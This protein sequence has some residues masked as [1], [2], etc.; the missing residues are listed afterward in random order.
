[1]NNELEIKQELNGE[2]TIDSREVAEMVEKPHD[3]LM[4][5][6]RGYI[7]VLDDSAKLQTPNFF[8]ES[9]YINSQ[10]K[11]QPCYLLTKKGCDMVANKMTGEKGILFTAEYVTKFDE[12]EKQ[13]KSNTPQISREQQLVLSIYNGGIEAVEATKELTQLKVAEAVAPLKL[14]IENDKPLVEFSNQISKSV[15]SIDIGQFSK[16][17]KDE[18]IDIGRN[19]LF[20]WLR[21][22][23]YLMKDNVPY[24]SKIE[25]GLFE[26]KEYTYKTPYGVKN[27]VKC[28]VTGK[29]QIFLVEKLRKE[30]CYEQLNASK[31]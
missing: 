8:I 12:M 2:L 6:I 10:N 9:T 19:R 11:Q 23:K 1:M 24:Q 13:I 26:V 30:F 15:N 28:L 18:N 27:G 31:E 21:D 20:Q 14:K 17:V 22:N 4:R 16:V 7:K 25:Q 29:G 3:Q 5:S